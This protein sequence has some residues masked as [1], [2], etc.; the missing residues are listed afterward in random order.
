MLLRYERRGT[1][2]VDNYWCIG[3]WRVVGPSGLEVISFR[4]GPWRWYRSEEGEY[5]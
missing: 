1:Q 4:C 3:F 2:E 5:I